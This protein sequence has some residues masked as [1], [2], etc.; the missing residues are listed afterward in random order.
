MSVEDLY[1]THERLTLVKLEVAKRV[2]PP[3]LDGI[4]RGKMKRKTGRKFTIV[5]YIA[6]YS[7][8]SFSPVVLGPGI[9][10]EGRDRMKRKEMVGK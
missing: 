3:H 10:V 4:A 7:P 6:K 5:Q 1:C 9:K 2:K 8:S